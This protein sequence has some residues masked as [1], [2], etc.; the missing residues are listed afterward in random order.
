MVFGIWTPAFTSITFPVLIEKA[1]KAAE[2][3]GVE[4]RAQ[5]GG[6]HLWGDPDEV[7]GEDGTLE[8]LLADLKDVGLDPDLTKLQLLG[9]TPDA[10]ANKPAW[11]KETFII[12]DP[13][14]AVRVAEA[15]A[16]A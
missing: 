11:L 9:T 6:I 13:I 1:L 4:P 12:T 15:Q 2:S 10:C 3:N 7:F 14:E 5:Q 16:A 8:T